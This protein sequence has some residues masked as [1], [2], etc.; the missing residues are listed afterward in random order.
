[1]GYLIYLFQNVKW[2]MEK[3]MK[4][5]MEY[6]TFKT[7]RKVKTEFATTVTCIVIL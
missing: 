6:L 7:I 5:K 2:D 4:S 1:M 3:I